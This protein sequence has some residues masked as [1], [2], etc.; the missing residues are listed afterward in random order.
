MEEPT[1]DSKLWNYRQKNACPRD[2]KCLTKCAI[3]KATVQE[4]TSSN[5]EM[6]IGLTENSLNKTGALM[7]RSERRHST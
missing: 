5:Q 2:G 6:F 7:F 3:Y 1:Q 4:I